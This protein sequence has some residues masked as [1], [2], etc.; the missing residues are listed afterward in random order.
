MHRSKVEVA[1]G[2]ENPHKLFTR[3][4]DF[5]GAEASFGRKRPDRLESP[6][7]SIMSTEL[8]QTA[9][10]VVEAVLLDPQERKKLVGFARARYGI[11]EEDAEDL[12]Q[13]TALELLRQRHYVRSPQAY[14]FTVFKHRCVRFFRSRKQQASVELDEQM[15][16]PTSVAG[17]E[18]RERH[19]AVRQA[20]CRISSTCRKLLSSFY[21]EGKSLKET[22]QES[23]YA[24]SGLGNTINRCLQRLRAC[25]E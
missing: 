23:T 8:P 15:P 20:L 13:E 22:S 3:N 25:M 5:F 6:D 7:T 12:L 9:R 10:Q 4:E 21:V 16:D 19:L 2:R 17:G 14:L 18:K 24:F 1:G 11:R